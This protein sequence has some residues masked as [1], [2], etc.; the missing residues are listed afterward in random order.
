MQNTLLPGLVGR[1]LAIGIRV[2]RKAVA[3]A[4]CL[5]STPPKTW[6]TAQSKHDSSLVPG[7]REEIA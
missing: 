6:K 3:M 7:I 4:E 5:N 1:A 2:K